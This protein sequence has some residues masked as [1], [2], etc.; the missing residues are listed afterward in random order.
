MQAVHT[1]YGVAGGQTK[2][3][4]MHVAADRGDRDDWDVLHGGSRYALAVHASGRKRAQQQV[5]A[6]W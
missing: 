6:L 2:M 1:D 3:S 5:P 4:V